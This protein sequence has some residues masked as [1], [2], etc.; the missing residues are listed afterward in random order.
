M[1]YLH[2]AGNGFLKIFEE[3][4]TSTNEIFEC[5]MQETLYMGLKKLEKTMVLSCARSV[6]LLGQKE[7]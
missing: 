4:I 5:L 2:D 1:E 6:F 7:A 3:T